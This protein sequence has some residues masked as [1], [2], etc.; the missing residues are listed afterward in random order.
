VAFSISPNACTEP[1][2]FRCIRATSIK[3]S[4][5]RYFSI[6]LLSQAPVPQHVLVQQGRPTECGYDRTLT[7]R[8]STPLVAVTIQAGL[9]KLPKTDLQS[10]V[11]A[12]FVL[13]ILCYHACRPRVSVPC[14]W[15]CS[16]CALVLFFL[17]LFQ[18]CALQE[19]RSREE[20]KIILSVSSSRGIWYT[21]W[22]TRGRYQNGDYT[23]S[24]S[25]ETSL[26]EGF[27]TQTTSSHT[28]TSAQ[29]AQ[30]NE[31]DA[32]YL[33]RTPKFEVII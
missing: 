2:P 14:S 24:A 29:S 3:T 23:A 33:S 13:V 32:H 18:W 28:S 30:S 8:H 6:F 9:E 26:V 21:I 20:E 19:C 25:F 31:C 22:T 7:K 16:T 4:P 27:S 1:G 11:R 15:L 17:H 12:F 5:L 10:L